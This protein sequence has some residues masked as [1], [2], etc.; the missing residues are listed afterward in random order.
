MTD[1]EK[2]TARFKIETD[3]HGRGGSTLHD[4]SSDEGQVAFRPRKKPLLDS[5][6][7]VSGE[8]EKPSAEDLAQPIIRLP[9]N[10]KPRPRLTAPAPQEK[11]KVEEEIE[12]VNEKA[13][14]RWIGYMVLLTA[15]TLSGIIIAILVSG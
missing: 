1:G 2:K 7:L 12:E 10:P 3:Q 6:T 15:L 8:W 14:L 5:R 4:P 13:A 9:A 11:V